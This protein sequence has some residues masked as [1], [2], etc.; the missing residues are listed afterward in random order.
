MR[1]V[2]R[3][4]AELL[5]VRW[6]NAGKLEPTASPVIAAISCLLISYGGRC[7]RLAMLIWYTYFN[8]NVFVMT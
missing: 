7:E 3:N 1:G 8:Y 5:V 2:V 6:C 4:P